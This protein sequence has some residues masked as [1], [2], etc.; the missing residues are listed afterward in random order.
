MSEKLFTTTIV[1]ITKPKIYAKKILGREQ[2]L[3]LQNVQLSKIT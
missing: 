3:G 2:N 1:G